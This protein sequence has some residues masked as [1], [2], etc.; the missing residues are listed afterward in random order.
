MDSKNHS[1]AMK[2]SRFIY[3]ARCFGSLVFAPLI[4]ARLDEP[5]MLEYSAL[6]LSTI[7]WPHIAYLFAKLSSSPYLMERMNMRLDCVF[8]GIWAVG[9]NFDE[10]FIVGTII[11]LALD[12]A[13][14]WG[15]LWA[16]EC[17]AYGMI[18]PVLVLVSGPTSYNLN[19]NIDSGS[20]DM[21]VAVLLY[22]L[23]IGQRAYAT[24]NK[25]R[26]AKVKIES[27][28]LQI[29]E[30]VL[31]RYLPSELINDIFDGKISM[32]TKPH[33]AQITILF[34]DLSGFTKMSGQ[35]GA[36]VVSEFLNDYLTTMNETIFENHG[37][38][39]KFIGDSIMVI[40]GAPVDMSAEE[41]AKNAAKCAIAM[42]NGMKLVNKKWMANGFDEVSM[43]IG[44]HQGRA[45]VGNFGSEQR[46]DYT[47]IGPS[48]NLAS[49][50]ETACEPG[51]IY[52]S[53]EVR[54]LLHNE[55]PTDLA[56]EFELKGIE[57]K[58]CL[59]KLVEET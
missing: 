8:A 18:F 22:C 38:I 42:Q 46:V 26:A 32:E 40:F 24:R 3:P 49:R 37:T 53:E 17:L 19:F 57:G 16:C 14:M 36:E 59:Y 52:V 13:G 39:D 4:W 15:W 12:R 54:E 10:V 11:F 35:H 47:A 29:K 50:I 51:R 30:Q 48:V 7:V 21:F 25:F 34:S 20:V 5:T 27:L 58:T 41:Q 44:I 2:A 28:N 56:G 33:I 23:I 1:N 43:R 9:T 31:S 45:V 6:F 55:P